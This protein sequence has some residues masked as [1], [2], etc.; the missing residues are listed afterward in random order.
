MS[1]YGGGGGGYP[2]AQGG[3]PP[4]PGGYP[5]APGGAG[6]PPAPGGGGYPPAP[7]GGGYP[8]SAPAGGGYPPAPGGGYPPAPGV[9]GYPPAPAPG[10]PP[11]QGG[12]PP[13]SAPG[14]YPPPAAPSG[15]PPAPQPGYPPAPAAPSMPMPSAAYSGG[16]GLPYGPTP[17][18]APGMGF[19]QPEPS[20]SY[21]D[22]YTNHSGFTGAAYAATA[23]R[24]PSQPNYAPAP[25]PGGPPMPSPMY[26]PPPAQVAT[27]PP[28]RPVQA[29]SAPTQQMANMS[30]A[31]TAAKKTVVKRG[32]GTVREK[33]NF[34]GHKEAEILRKAMKGIGTDEKAIISVLGSCSNA[35]RQK[36]LIDFKTMYGKDLIKD[37]KSELKG[38]FEDIVLDMMATQPQFDARQLRK[39]MKGLGTDEAVLIEILC[40]RT[41]QEIHAIKDAY[42]KEFARNLE[43]DVI[44]E[45]SGHFQ[46]LLVS[47]TQGARQ[48]TD[49]VD[50]A[51]AKADAQALW[52]A[53][54]KRWGTDESQFNVILA[55][56]SFPQLRAIFEE[57]SRLGKYSIE[58]SIKREMSGDLEKGMLTIVACVRSSPKYFA[59]KLHKSMK[60]LGTDDD[61]LVRVVVS[62]CEIDM[63]EIKQEFYKEYKQTL[64]KFIAGD[65]SGD[66]KRILLELVGGES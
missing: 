9:G 11:A 25:A 40:T 54:E 48:E 49:T 4:A 5:P 1:Y 28:P 18:Q 65:T 3:Y 64:G 46:R 34:D 30:I 56:R 15:Y 20:S 26:N 35:Q 22:P 27:A 16:A 21:N 60:G 61:T 47:M 10:Y 62:R 57:Y 53:G 17:G 24:P 51:K 2:P 45:T 63:V 33:A 41:N 14:G 55:S 37:L 50:M 12:Y 43:K 8:P 39:A 13:A 23:F 38:K 36:I 32:T 58:Q 6:Y 29:A 31:S 19:A 52:E 66:Y 42:K 7:G 59:E 44:S